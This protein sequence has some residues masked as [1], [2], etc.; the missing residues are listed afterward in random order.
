[1]KI[2]N[3]WEFGKIKDVPKSSSKI[4]SGGNL[5]AWAITDDFRKRYSK[6]DCMAFYYKSP[7]I[8]SGINLFGD[9]CLGRFFD[10]ESE[11]K[12][13]KVLCQDVVDLPSFKPVLSDAIKHTVAVGD[14]FMEILWGEESKS[15]CGFK[16]I[17]P[18][19]IEPKYDDYGNILHYEQTI[20]K[21]SQEPTKLT[22]EQV[23]HLRFWRIGD[24]MRGIGFVEPLIPTLEIEFDILES[25]REAI[26]K[27]A[28]PPLN[29]TIKS[30][31]ED[32]VSD[33]EIDAL[34]EKYKDFDRNKFFA[35]SDRIDINFMKL[36]QAFPDLTF[37]MDR[38]LNI[39]C[40]GVRVPKPILLAAG[41]TTNRAT[42]DSL[43]NF[44][45]WEISLIQEKIAR[46]I[47]EQ[48]FTTLCRRNGFEVFPD[49]NWRP[50]ATQDDTQTAIND[51]RYAKAMSLL[52]NSKIISPEE[53]KE[54]I[55]K[56][57]KK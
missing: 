57:F 9:S 35:S 19:T 3:R 10:L 26:Q 18:T 8:F 39:I 5:E 44:N 16:I 7:L 32:P 12:G 25:I 24:S 40:A 42:L 14:G 27:F 31:P 15:I 11:K 34:K 41:E 46:A 1:M 22:T 50:M 52:V 30:T 36:Y 51:L 20:S 2:F 56:H 4:S 29:V 54:L 13:A 53:A 43:I 23:A 37:Q 47:E 21:L 55:A 33:D 6:K 28:N 17:D 49:I 38:I 48:I 45:R